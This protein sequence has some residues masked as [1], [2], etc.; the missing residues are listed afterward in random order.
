MRIFVFI[1]FVFI[2]GFYHYKCEAQNQSKTSDPAKNILQTI[3]ST[4]IKINKININDVDMIMYNDIVI[5]EIETKIWNLNRQFIKDSAEN[6]IKNFAV[7]TTKLRK[8]QDTLKIM[9]TRTDELIRNLDLI[10]YCKGLTYLENN[11]TDDAINMFEKS[12]N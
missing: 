4:L 8:V 6:K 7:I 12:V 10:Y 9:R 5:D 11:M 3:D 1:F 2:T